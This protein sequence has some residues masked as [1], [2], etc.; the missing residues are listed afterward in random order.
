MII[1]LTEQV[2]VIH[3]VEA[4]GVAQ[5]KDPLCKCHLSIEVP[6]LTAKDLDSL[7]FAGSIKKLLGD[8]KGIEEGDPNTTKASFKRKWDA[9]SFTVRLK[10]KD[11]TSFV[12]EIKNLV[13][14][15]FVEGIAS[16]R[17]TVETLIPA[18]KVGLL[19]SLVDSDFT[20]VSTATTQ[21]TLP[22]LTIAPSGNGKVAA[23]A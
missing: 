22:G 1:P 12:A 2:A 16:L 5:G 3:S 23:I 11:K 15:W 13:G 21:M 4:R 10:G 18:E 19:A 6:K 17:F 8:S 9:M 20:A 7:P 14:V